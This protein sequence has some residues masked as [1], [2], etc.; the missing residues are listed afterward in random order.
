MAVRN[1]SKRKKKKTMWKVRK[2]TQWNQE[3]IKEE[4]NTLSQKSQK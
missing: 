2:K 4:Q 3:E 1:I